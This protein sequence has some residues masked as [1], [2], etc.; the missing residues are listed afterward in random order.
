MSASMGIR[1]YA[2]I[3]IWTNRH[4]TGVSAER[5]SRKRAKCA[6]ND[7]PLH[8][9]HRRRNAARRSQ[10]RVRDGGGTGAE[11][12]SDAAIGAPEPGDR[13]ITLSPTAGSTP[14]AGGTG[15]EI[16]NNLPFAAAA[17]RS[18]FVT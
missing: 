5:S 16:A 2:A 9:L 7:H 14:A 12:E 1:N 3:G 6:V 11:A 10:S 15:S 13:R 4:A 17:L 18:S 8:S